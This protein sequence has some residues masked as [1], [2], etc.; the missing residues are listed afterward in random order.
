MGEDGPGSLPDLPLPS[1][2]LWLPLSCEVTRTTSCG[3]VPK[4]CLQGSVCPLFLKLILILL[5]IYLFGCTESQL[6]H[7]GSSSLTRDQIWAPALG[8]KSPNR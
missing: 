8:I 4:S 1:V 5:L 3:S 6:R 7:V 2:S